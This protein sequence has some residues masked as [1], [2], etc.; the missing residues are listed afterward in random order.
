M[1]TTILLLA[2]T[3]PPAV[4]AEKQD[5]PDVARPWTYEEARQHAIKNKLHL[6]VAVGDVKTDGRPG[7]PT[8]VW[9]KDIVV[10]RATIDYWRDICKT[11]DLSSPGYA[12]GRWNG[13]YHERVEFFCHQFT[14][15]ELFKA[16]QPPEPV[17]IAETGSGAIGSKPVTF[18][19]KPPE[20]VLSASPAKA[21][22]TTTAP[23]AS[24]R[25]SRSSSC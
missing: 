23:A 4:P 6:V 10:A 16:L 18:R 8:W 20:P 2:I 19:L 13:K 22:F 3:A 5:V 14:A 11:T 17:T 21:V 12:V 15:E 25:F 1:F 9:Q 24:Y 7:E